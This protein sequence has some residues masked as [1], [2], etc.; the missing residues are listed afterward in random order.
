MNEVDAKV[1]RQLVKLWTTF[2]STGSPQLRN[3]NERAQWPPMTGE[4]LIDY[5]FETELKKDIFFQVTSV[6]T[7]T[8]IETLNRVKIIC[9]NL[10]SNLGQ[11]CRKE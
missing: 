5:V 6:G 1:S 8:S 11:I 7:F 2:A 10:Q 9:V 4:I 3:Q